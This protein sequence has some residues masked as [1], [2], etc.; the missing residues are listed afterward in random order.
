MTP[1]LLQDFMCQYIAI[2]LIIANSIQY[3]YLPWISGKSILSL[4]SSIFYF[5][6]SCFLTLFS[7]FSFPISTCSK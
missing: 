1:K 3:F 6:S 2:S 7:I 4:F 5:L